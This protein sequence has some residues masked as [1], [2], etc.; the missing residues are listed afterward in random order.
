MTHDSPKVRTLLTNELSVP[1]PLH[2]SLSRSLVLHTDKREEFLSRV[3]NNVK[4]MG[5]KPFFATFDKIAW[6][7]NFDKT[8]W[9]LSLSVQRLE[10][11]ELNRLL[12]ASNAA[13]IAMEQPTLYAKSKL[14][15][16]EEHKSKKR[17]RSSLSRTESEAEIEVSDRSDFFHVSLAWSLETQ[18]LDCGRETVMPGELESLA[19]KFDCVKVKIGNTVTSLPL[20]STKLGQSGKGLLG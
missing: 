1:L 17:R 4:T 10:N 12:G 15:V 18:E 13:C 19:A 11:D 3:R 5:V 8:R 14:V 20:I 6:Y 9:F 16:L 2:I 7:P